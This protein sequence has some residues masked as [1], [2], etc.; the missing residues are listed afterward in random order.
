MS[1]RIIKTTEEMQN[2]SRGVHAEGKKIGFVPTMGFLH[3]G[4]LS[5]VKKATEVSDVVVV[6]IFVNPTQFAPNED[7]SRY[8]RDFERDK[9]LLEENYAGV[10][11]FPD[12][13]EIYGSGFQTFVEVGEITKILEGEFRPTHFRGVTTVVNILFN[14]VEPDVAVFGRK[15][16]QQAAVI[17]RMVSDLKMDIEILIEPI[18]RESDGLAM[19]SRNIYLSGQERSDALVL[20]RSL[21][22][23]ETL[24]KSGEREA[25]RIISE[26]KK[27]Y[28][29]IPSAKIDY[30]AVVESKSFT[31]AEYLEERKSY[32]F[33]VACRIGNTR[34][35][36][37]LLL[38]A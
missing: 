30:I 15:D 28:E 16:A 19:S 24:V 14:V 23:A 22:L 2:Y 8:P 37:N 5:L 6:S 17:K 25:G 21:K 38:I 9:S 34:L 13:E 18:V 32:Y 11:F 4:H 33:L 31:F 1:F 26:M 29:E 7:L 27:M 20:S 3:E 36:D 12:A 35:I 10:I